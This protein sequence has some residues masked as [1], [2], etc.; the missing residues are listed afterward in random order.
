MASI[1]AAATLLLAGASLAAPLPIS[2]GEDRYT[3]S[4]KASLNGEETDTSTTW[5]GAVLQSTDVTSVT[6]TFTI[7]SVSAPSGGDPSTSYCG[8]AWVGIDGVSNICVNGGLMQ[9]GISW[10]VQNGAATYTPWSE[11]FPAEAQINF[12]NFPV[13]VGD[14]IQVTITATSTI[15]GSAVLENVASGASVTRNW[16]NV[17]PALC[18]DTAEW[19]VEDF[20]SNG[21]SVP[22]SSFDTVTWTNANAQV[23]GA[24]TGAGS[25]TPWNMVQNGNTLAT[26]S[27]SGDDVVITYG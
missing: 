15:S 18:F 27:L 26:G 22:F 24:T 10:C 7:P 2:Q 4:V 6:G 12:D 13:A 9:A 3:H 5:G 1:Y 11:Y 25:A 20:E 16:S 14:Q 21:G 17:S 8:S 23:N 19:I